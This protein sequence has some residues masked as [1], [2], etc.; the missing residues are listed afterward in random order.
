MYKKIAVGT[1]LSA[2]SAIAVAHAAALAGKLGAEITLI[3]AGRDPG[4][5]L[6]DLAAKH[7][8]AYEAVEG[9]PAEVLIAEAGR[10]DVDLL[11]VGSVGM[12]GARRFALGNVPNKVS[13]HIDR[14]LL[15]VKTD[16]GEAG[17]GSYQK[18]LVGA[19]GSATAMRAVEAA[20]ELAK[21]LGT[22]P[23]IVT[24]FEPPTEHELEQLRVGTSD[25]IS[26][27]SASKTQLE[28]PA[29]F[30][31][32]IAGAA[33]AEDVLDRAADHA[34]EMGVEAE[35]RAIEGSPAEVLLT[36]AEK[37]SF[38]LIV[39][40]SVGMAGA[41]RFMLGNVPNRLSHHTPIDILILHTA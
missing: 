6:A 19:D 16:K 5:A 8:A 13:H 32:R 23:T 4:T 22:T 20:S 41:K 21:A 9:P 40:G 28:T 39:V 17:S 15:I 18:I 2:T 33:Q 1:D 29:G 3:Y 24:A 31:W 14:D 27:W 34:G 30:E 37:E 26:T 25:A 12:S 38:D 36:V 11:C 10:L 7:G 35:V